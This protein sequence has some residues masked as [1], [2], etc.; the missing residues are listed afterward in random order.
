MER[1]VVPCT[2]PRH[3]DCCAD[4]HFGHRCTY[5]GKVMPEERPRIPALGESLPEPGRDGPRK[6]F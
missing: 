2:D 4:L 6:L 5:C 3:G 1:G